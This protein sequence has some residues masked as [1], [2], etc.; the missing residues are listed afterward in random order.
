LAAI[1]YDPILFEILSINLE[2]TASRLPDD[3]TI[4][5]ED[6][7]VSMDINFIYFVR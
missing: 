7:A 4:Q 5:E 6:M 1:S 2:H 3:F